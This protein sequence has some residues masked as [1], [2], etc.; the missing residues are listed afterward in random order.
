[1]GEE[2]CDSLREALQTL[3]RHVLSSPVR[4]AAVLLLA[5]R[6]ELEFSELQRALGTTPGALWSHIEKLREHGI[7][8]LRRRLSLRGPRV[9]ISLTETGRQELEK[10][11][12]ALDR[13]TRIARSQ[14]L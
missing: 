12:N 14:N 6:G 4:L 8:E 5:A 13:L 1:M 7:V 10:Y 2:G 3:R 11:L 9:V